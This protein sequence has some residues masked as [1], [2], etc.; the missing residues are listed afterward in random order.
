MQKAATSQELKDA[1][2]DH[3]SLTEEHVDRLERVFEI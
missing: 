3:T 1:I 2:E